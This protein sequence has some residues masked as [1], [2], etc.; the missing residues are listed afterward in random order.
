MTI[1]LSILISVVVITFCTA[2]KAI[3]KNLLENPEKDKK[4]TGT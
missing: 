2:V 4:D 1:V 3:C